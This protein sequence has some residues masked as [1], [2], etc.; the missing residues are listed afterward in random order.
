MSVAARMMGGMPMKGYR[1]GCHR[2]KPMCKKGGAGGTE[3]VDKSSR[4][5]YVH[6]LTCTGEI[7]GLCVL[8]ITSSWLWR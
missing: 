7:E 1:K 6:S 3:K 2:R 4:K 5:A 8:V